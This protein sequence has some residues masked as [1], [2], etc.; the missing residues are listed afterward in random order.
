MF[1]LYDNAPEERN[2]PAEHEHDDEMLESSMPP[3]L[4]LHWGAENA[5]GIPTTVEE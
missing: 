5:A 4:A 2:Y 1:P 3:I